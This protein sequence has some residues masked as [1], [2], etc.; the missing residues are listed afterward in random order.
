MARTAEPDASGA[1][2]PATGLGAVALARA[3]RDGWLDPVEHTEA[4]L[5]LARTTGALVGAFSHVAPE[6][7]RE[8]AAAARTA[9]REGRPGR[10]I[11]VPVPIKALAQVE[12]LPADNGSTA[13]RG[14]IAD[15]TDGAAQDLLDA[16][17]V[18]IGLTTVPE[19]GMPCYTEPAGRTPARTPWDLRRT[20]GGSSGGAAAAVASGI[21][22]IAHGS[23][24]GGS[25]R[26]PAACCGIVGFKPSRGVVSPGPFGVEG[27]GL[28]TDGVLA[29]S[30]ADIAVGMDAIA[31]TRP[32]DAFGIELRGSFVDA[33]AAARPGGLRIGVLTEPLA[34]DAPVHPAALAAVQRA[35]EALRA[36]GHRLDEVPRPFAPSQ[37][38]AFMP[39]WAA[40][41]AAAELPGG[42]E[43]QLMPLTRWLREQGRACTGVAHARALADMQRVARTMGERYDGYDLILTPALAQPPAFPED[44]Q[45]ADPAADFDAQCAFT[46]W[47]STWNMT[48]RAAVAVPLHREAVDGV[49]LPFGVQL[50]AVRAADDHLVLAVAAQ[51]EERDPWP[52]ITEPRGATARDEGAR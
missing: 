27:P 1:G 6:M 49:E 28:V 51:L 42:A 12:G 5:E 3:M 8:Q 24:G 10:L 19:L 34:I 31:R 50:G 7:S 16:G 13:L 25:I 37:W 44:L 52:L 33:L 40:G 35:V 9:L 18:T 2:E 23:D 41:A 46:P 15:R 47:T 20:A 39:L 48:G 43:E 36:A 29:R 17:T 14:E 22:P 11:G 30:V 26:I 45:L 38:R 21:V 32:G 4:V